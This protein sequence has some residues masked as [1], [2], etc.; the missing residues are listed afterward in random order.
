MPPNVRSRRLARSRRSV[1]R[2]VRPRSRTAARRQSTRS[3]VATRMAPG[4]ARP[5]ASSSRWRRPGA[6]PARAGGRRYHQG[7]TGNR[8]RSRDPPQAAGRHR[9][10]ST[11]RD[12]RGPGIPRPPT[13]SQ[14][15]QS[16]TGAGGPWA[17][18]SLATA[19][20]P[21]DPYELTMQGLGQS[22]T[23]PAG[24]QRRRSC[25]S[26]L[27]AGRGRSLRLGT[28]TMRRMPEPHAASHSEPLPSVTLVLPAYNE[29]ARIGPALDELFAYLDGEP[30]RQG[31]RPPSDMGPVEVLVVDDGSTDDTVAIVERRPEVAS[32][33][34]EAAPRA[35]RW[36]GCRRARRNARGRVGRHPVRRCRPGYATRPAAAPDRGTP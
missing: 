16:Q 8:P 4:P 10:S 2:P 5:A 32:G 19:V 17:R 6:W 23:T 20:L 22:S 11:N 12:K 28:D 31:G 3:P 15:R 35:A 7:S 30:D 21:P 1:A 24:R 33:P 27:C 9:R 25:R 18:C 13:A 36:Q 14:R 29:A 34:A 26:R